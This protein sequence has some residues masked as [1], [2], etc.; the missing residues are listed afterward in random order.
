MYALLRKIERLCLP[1]WCSLLYIGNA[2]NTLHHFGIP[3]WAITYVAE[4]GRERRQTSR[5]A[6]IYRCRDNWLFISQT[7][8]LI[9]PLL[10][11]SQRREQCIPQQRPLYRI[12]R[13]CCRITPTRCHLSTPHALQQFRTS[14]HSWAAFV[15][16][17]PIGALIKYSFWML[18]TYFSAHIALLF[19]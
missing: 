5:R 8:T 18:C 19:S 7:H 1:C 6:A 13:L 16:R 2:Q 12:K 9:P 15:V 4:R 11:L 14:V 17:L 3:V 10:P